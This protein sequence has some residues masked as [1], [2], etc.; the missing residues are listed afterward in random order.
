MDYATV[1][2]ALGIA[3]LVFIVIGVIGGVVPFWRSRTLSPAS[4]QRRVFWTGAV[5][6][7]ALMFVSQLPEWRSSVF[8]A[9]AATCA[10]LLM[11]YRFTPLIKIRGRVYEYMRDPRKPDPPPALASAD[12]SRR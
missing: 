7:V 3:G 11:A 5:T 4:V 12:D 8:G 2:K 10:L 6:G 1:G 9:L